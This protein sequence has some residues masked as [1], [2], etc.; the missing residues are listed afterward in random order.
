[1]A[2]KENQSREEKAPVIKLNGKKI[3]VGENAIPSAPG[4]S[5]K[6]QLEGLK[7]VAKEKIFAPAPKEEKAQPSKQDG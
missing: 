2:E 3:P 4:A 5:P 6:E 1:M 7:R